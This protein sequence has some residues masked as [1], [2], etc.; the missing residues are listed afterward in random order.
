MTDQTTQRTNSRAEFKT[1][2]A[3]VKAGEAV[4]FVFTIKDAEGKV[5]RDLQ[6]VHEKAM[7]L[8]VISDD[9]SEFYHLHPKQHQD[10]SFYVTHTFTHGGNYL[11]YADYTLPDAKSIVDQFS[12]Q[13]SGKARPKVAL[14]EDEK[15]TKI[16]GGLRVTMQ[17]NKPLRS[18]EEVMLNFNFT[19]ADEQTN[20]PVTDL[21]P[22]LG[23][24]AHFVI[25][26]EDGTEFLHAHPME[27]AGITTHG[28]EAHEIGEAIPHTHGDGMLHTSGTPQASGPEVIAHTSFPHA[29][30]YKVWAQFQRGGRVITASFVLHVMGQ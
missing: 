12:L 17:P 7:H 16:V 23:A 22:Y 10:G 5:I 3:E 30:L 6:V 15:A 14:L 13:V 8:L 4:T 24:L 11:L 25:I 1:K 29:G 18:G 20:K 21:E 9:L 19:V 27:K 2:P 28:H 26:S